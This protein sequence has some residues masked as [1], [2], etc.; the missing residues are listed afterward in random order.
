[1]TDRDRSDHEDEQP[2]A[3]QLLHWATG[4]REAEA[5]ALA[6]AADG[7]VSEDDAELAVRRTH[8]DLGPK[9]SPVDSDVATPEDAEAAHEE[10][11]RPQR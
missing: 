4:D 8:G 5:K 10:R 1:M 2:S 9:E 3:R 11:A 6:D 7:E